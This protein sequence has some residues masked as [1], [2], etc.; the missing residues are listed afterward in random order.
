MATPWSIETCPFESGVW[1]GSAI[2][3]LRMTVTVSAGVA[4]KVGM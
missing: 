3:D 2:R 4:I 1:S